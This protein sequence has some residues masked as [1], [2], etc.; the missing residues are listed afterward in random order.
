ML[1]SQVKVNQNKID[2]I[3][4]CQTDL[5]SFTKGIFESSHKDFVLNWHHRI[6]CNYLERV[7]IGD[8]NRLII[9]L[10]P[11]YSKTELAVINFMAWSIGIFP[12]AEF[13]H[14]TYSK[15]LATSNTWKTKG[16]IESE[17]YKEIFPYLT[18]RG[19]SKAKDEWRTTVGGV[20]YA[21]GSDGTITGY[22]AGKMRNTFGGA[23]IIDDPHKA[24]EGNSDIRRQNVI[25]WFITTMESRV[26]NPAT[27]II[28]IM[29]RLHEQ[30]LSGFLL[31]GGN[32]EEWEHLMIPAINSKEEALWDYK[33]SLSDLRRMEK[34][35]PYVFTGQYMQTPSPLGG[36][37][38][39]DEW[40][41]FYD[42]LPNVEYR[43]I[44][45]D[46]AQKTKEYNDYS[47]FQCWG[48]LDGNI[49]L[50]DQIR[51]KWEAPELKTQFVAFWMKHYGS[52]SQTRG[53]LRRAYI[54]D[55]VSGTGLIQDIKRDKNNP[56]PIMGVGRSI[57]KVSRA[58]DMVSYIASGYVFLPKNA[59][60]LSDYLSEFAKFTPLMSHAHDDQIDPTLDAIDILLRPAT[61]TA[62][63]W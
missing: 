28:L 43:I 14:A 58:M 44:T 18:L 4:D 13:I 37:L 56:I 48:Y 51:G 54:E 11:R 59:D 8:I 49:Y 36:G 20:V 17:A 45:G 46:T 34:S 50:T 19:D 21:T 55:K 10:P 38:F 35:N 47:V 12:D 57:D 31:D 63:I 40:W 29:Q 7:V 15:R 33:H 24:S 5:L 23:I 39:K 53:K 41:K 9:N 62:G 16:I 32:G 22:G 27:P 2:G 52:G 30:D 60:Y 25:D 1:N 26:N 6:I 61:A 42:L 3:V